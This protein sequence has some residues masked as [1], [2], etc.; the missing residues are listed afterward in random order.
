MLST[1]M[2]YDLLKIYNPELH[3][4]IW[5]WTI[6]NFRS[7]LPGKS[8]NEVFGKWAKKAIKQ[9]YTDLNNQDQ[10]FVDACE[11][12]AYA[13]TLVWLRAFNAVGTATKVRRFMRK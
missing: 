7:K 8:E 10:E 3:A 5:G 11:A 13:E 12:M 6:E 9:Y 4:E 2:V 1:Y